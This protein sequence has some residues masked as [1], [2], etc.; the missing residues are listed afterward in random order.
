MRTSL[1]SGHVLSRE[2]NKSNIQSV[3]Q[4]FDVTRS[5]VQIGLPNQRRHFPPQTKVN[6]A[7]NFRPSTLVPWSLID[8]WPR[9]AFLQFLHTVQPTCF[10]KSHQYWKILHL[11]PRLLRH[12][13]DGP[14]LQLRLQWPTR[15]FI[16][17]SLV[18]GPKSP[19]LLILLYISWPC[20]RPYN[21]LSSYLWWLWVVP[22]KR[23]LGLLWLWQRP[24]RVRINGIR[25]R[26]GER[27]N[28]GTRWLADWLAGSLRHGRI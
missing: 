19:I 27:Q 16:L 3:K 25:Q 18:L 17:T 24:F 9:C 28:G 26:S 23:R 21:P 4:V 22:A 14:I 12:G 7:I 1:E 15:I 6:S 2:H 8:I 13:Q 20:L 5:C 10:F 11:W